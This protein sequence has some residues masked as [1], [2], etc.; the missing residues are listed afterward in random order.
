[1]IRAERT[2][3][4]A[5]LNSPVR[6]GKGHLVLQFN[7]T[8]DAVVG[9]ALAT[10]GITVLG[11]VPENG[12]L[13]SLEGRATVVGL[14]TVYAD[15]LN[16]ADKISPLISGAPGAVPAVSPTGYYLVEFYPDV[17]MNVARAVV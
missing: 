7:R 5:E 3:A 6:G 11:D 17:N 14:G 2:S 12:L 15:R 1:M 8:P 16:P 4:I 13:V 10:R 9:A